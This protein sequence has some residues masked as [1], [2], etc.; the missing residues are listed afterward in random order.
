MVV[1]GLGGVAVGIVGNA[2]T[3]FLLIYYNQVLG[4]PAYLVSLA[5]AVALLFD[6]FSDP[7][8]G[9]LSDRTRSRLGRRHPYIYASLVPLPIAYWLLW[10]PPAWAL[11]SDAATFTY[12]TVLLIVFRLILTLYDIPSNAMV[13]ELT[14]DYDQRTRLMSARLATAWIGGVLFTVAMYGV[15]LQPTAAYPDGVLN[16]AGYQRASWFGAGLIATSILILALGTH[17]ELPVLSS[18]RP[19][20]PFRPRDALGTVAMIFGN[21][22]FRAVLLFALVTTS[23][24]GLTEAL[25]IYTASYF[26]GLD[27]DQIAVINFMNLFGVVAAL[28]VVPRLTQNRNKKPVTITLSLI[29]LVVYAGPITG[30][31]AGLVPPEAAYPL[32]IV[33]SGIETFFIVSIGALVASMLSDV[34]EDT[35]VASGVRHEGGILAAQTFVTKLATAAGTWLAGIV[36]TLIAFPQTDA[37]AAVPADTLF[38]LGA[39]YVS[40]IAGSILTGVLLLT[41]YGIDRAHHARNLAA[42]ASASAPDT[43]GHRM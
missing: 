3:Y 11:T 16:P 10:N 35:E 21:V 43:P 28:G 15:W 25:W 12:F 2:V 29:G 19:L 23:A 41:P 8:V 5:L 37:V 26:W 42:V 20:T 17:R 13:P 18:A 36:L 39:V 4:T 7:V 33:Q 24:A 1:F 27:T 34:V 40:V 22:S 6:A 31:L 32:L 38:H 30:G 14:R 9:M